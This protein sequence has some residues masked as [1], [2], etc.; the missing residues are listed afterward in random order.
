MGSGEVCSEYIVLK[1]SH[2]GKS[3]YTEVQYISVM[4]LCIILG[5]CYDNEGGGSVVVKAL[6]YKL[7]G[8]G[9]DSRWCH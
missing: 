6:G 2:C 7:A 1:Y 4:F 3:V 8:R 9:F 5:H